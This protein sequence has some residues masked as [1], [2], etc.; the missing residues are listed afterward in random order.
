MKFQLNLTLKE[1]DYL[2]FNLF[3]NLESKQT[4][5]INKKVRNIFIIAM[6]ALMGITLV[7]SGWDAFSSTYIILLLLITI[8]FALLFKHFIRHTVKMQVKTLKKT[9]KLPYDAESTLE[10]YEDKIV[11]ITPTKRIEQSYDVLERICLLPGRYIFL[12][13]SSV[14]AYILPIAQIKSQ[15]DYEDFWR[16]LC[17]KC[18]NIEQYQ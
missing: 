13:T 12:Y 10:F 6:V 11:E 14:G 7:T 18:K 1:E 8:A 16:F 17:L 2:A 15:V 3:H 5:K 4:Q 9:G